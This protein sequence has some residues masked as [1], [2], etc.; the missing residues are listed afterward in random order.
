MLNDNTLEKDQKPE[1]NEK[2]LH[3][4]WA[5]LLESSLILAKHTTDFAAAIEKKRSMIESSL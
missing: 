4:T 3:S 5:V 2:E 1:P